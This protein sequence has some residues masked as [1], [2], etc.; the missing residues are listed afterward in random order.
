MIMKI[1]VQSELLQL[2]GALN[3]ENII[4]QHRH[5]MQRGLVNTP[6]GFYLGIAQLRHDGDIDIGQ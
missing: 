4:T 6:F 5:P 2:F 1:M 3:H